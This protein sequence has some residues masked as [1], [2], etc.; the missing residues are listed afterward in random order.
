MSSWALPSKPRPS[1]DF[2][3]AKAVAHPLYLQVGDE[4]S[5]KASETVGSNVPSI[6]IQDEQEIVVPLQFRSRN[7]GALD[8]DAKRREVL[9]QFLVE[10]DGPVLSSLLQEAG[11]QLSEQQQLTM[12]LQRMQM[13][14]EEEAGKIR[15]RGQTELILHAEQMDAEI[16]ECWGRGEKVKAL[17]VAIQSC[18]MLGQ[19][20]IPD[21]YP[22]IFILVAQVLDTF[23]DFV[24]DRLQ[25]AAAGQSFVVAALIKRGQ[26]AAAVDVIPPEVVEM[27]NNWFLKISSIRELLPRIYIELSLLKCYR[28]VAK[29]NRLNMRDTVS[30]LGKQI[31]GVANPVVAAHTRW[32]LFL[33]AAEGLKG[34]HYAWCSAVSTASVASLD[35]QSIV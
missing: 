34:G 25:S 19:Q 11:E 7:D 33:R 17:R 27:C 30:R 14:R 5:S 26:A 23:G 2:K 29:K 35:T 31:R 12:K 18:K 8:R 13:E 22:S 16:K 3:G 20:S 9:S 6:S 4:G 1:K 24:A 28:Y 21:S 15:N 32:Y 10:D